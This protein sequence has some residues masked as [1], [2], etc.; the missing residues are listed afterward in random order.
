[1]KASSEKIRQRILLFDTDLRGHH[2]DYLNYLVEFHQNNPVFELVVVTDER[3]TQRFQR[4]FQGNS[5]NLTF[6]GIPEETI[7]EL[8]Q[9][10][11]IARSYYEWQLFCNYA[12]QHTSTHGVLMY[13]DVFQIGL[14]A[15]FSSPCPVSGIYF[16]PDFHYESIG[17]KVK[18][19]SVRKKWML[20][21]ILR[22]PFVKNVFSLDKKAAEVI[23]RLGGTANVL[24]I[25]DPVKSYE[26]SPELVAT[27]KNKLKIN[28]EKRVFLLFGFLDERKGIE[29]VVEAV[30]QLSV[31]E[32][33]SI[34]IIL[35]GAIE[36]DYQ[37]KIED[38]ISNN[39]L[40][41]V[42]TTVFKEIRGESIQ[43]FFE[44]SDYVLA[45]YQHHVGMSQILV[46]AA[47]SQK[48]LISSDFGLMGEIVREKHLGETV[49]STDP[50]KIALAVRKAVDKGI[51]A[52]SVA[53][54]S[55]AEQN[56]T[57]AFAETIFGNILG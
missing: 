3:L 57:Q 4:T 2:T 8:H 12:R 23:E 30:L 43:H 1:M 6:I 53:M 7:S 16:R 5:T 41:G 33:Q 32:K 48:P 47:I 15:S 28:S 39:N 40:S 29:K 44:M 26:N 31:I 20:Q 17:W 36:A 38:L 51:T 22:K 35:A 54:K 21:L 37:K 19:N 25:S 49:N 18:L 46:R 50:D 56:S 9:K 45:L 52:D 24:P 14:I 10:N 34:Q 11:I 55:F 42:F 27:L 13:F